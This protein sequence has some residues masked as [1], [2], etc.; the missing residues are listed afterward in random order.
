MDKNGISSFLMDR[1]RRVTEINLETGK[2][3]WSAVGIGDPSLELNGETIDKQDAYG[4]MIAQID[5]AK[6][7]VFGASIDTP[8]LQVLASQRGATIEVGSEDKMI[9]S[10]YFD[11]VKVV[12]GKATLTYTPKEA[13]P[14]VYAIN[15]DQ[16][17]GDEYEVGLEDANAKIEG[18]VVTLPE[19]FTATQVGVYYKYETADA[20]KLTDNSDTFGT[21]AKYL[22][23]MYVRDI[24]TDAKRVGVL[25]FPKAK[26]DNN[27]TIDLTTEGSHPI[28]LTAQK[29]YCA[30]ESNLYYWVWA[31]K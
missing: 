8:N 24:C 5:T 12:D 11:V 25:I 4:A 20:V 31:T 9:E 28:S 7:A 30:D 17:Q 18:N 26:L 29:E 19:G 22:I 3:N 2:V 6:G 10:E 14:Y 27:V 15:S 16:T 21:A 1:V 23:Q 13:P